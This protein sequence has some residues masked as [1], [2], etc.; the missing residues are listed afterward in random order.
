MT[1][2]KDKTLADWKAA[3]EKE[4]RGKSLDDRLHGSDRI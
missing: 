2:G 3:A 4:L 1:D